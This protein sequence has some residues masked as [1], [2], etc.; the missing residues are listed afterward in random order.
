M[1]LE[2]EVSFPSSLALSPP[3]FGLLLLL[4]GVPWRVPLW[5]VVVV[6][7]AAVVVVI[8]PAFASAASS[9]TPPPNSAAPR[10]RRIDLT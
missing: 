10:V 7:V 6:A 8:A 2:V 1:S 9:S 5:V 3:P 4:C